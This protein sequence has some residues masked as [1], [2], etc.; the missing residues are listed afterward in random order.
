MPI[1]RIWVPLVSYLKYSLYMSGVG[2]EDTLI[3]RILNLVAV[4]EVE[5]DEDRGN[6]VI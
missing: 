6:E 5:V 2:G 3:E 4:D 1:S